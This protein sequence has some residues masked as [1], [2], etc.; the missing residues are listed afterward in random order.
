[1]TG[2]HAYLGLGIA[3]GGALLWSCVAR[4][5]PIQAQQT[6]C[7]ERHA[8]LNQLRETYAERPA[9]LGVVGNGSV[10]E[11]LVSPSGSWTLLLSMPTGQT[12]M[13]ANGESWEPRPTTG[14]DI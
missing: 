10:M 2:R 8:L 13:I 7:G 11:L 6:A 1:M 12:C 9:G 5:E 4:A 14:K 3:L